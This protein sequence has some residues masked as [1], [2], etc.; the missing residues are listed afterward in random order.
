MRQRGKHLR[1]VHPLVLVVVAGVVVAVTGKGAEFTGC[2]VRVVVVRRHVDVEHVVHK[3]VGRGVRARG[4]RCAW[5]VWIGL[6]CG[7]GRGGV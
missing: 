1:N 6:G 7:E 4:H 2:I 3:G 5:G